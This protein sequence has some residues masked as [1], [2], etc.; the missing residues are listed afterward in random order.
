M[1]SKLL[2]IITVNYNSG[3]LLL[4]TLPKLAHFSSSSGVELI[5]VDGGSSDQS[6]P[7]IEKYK[8]IFTHCIIEKDKGIYDAMNKGIRHSSGE[9]VWFINAGDQPL[10]SPDAL[11]TILSIVGESPVNF[12]YSDLIIGGTIIRQHLDFVTI[13][14]GMINH[15]TIIYKHSLLRQPYDASLKYCSDYGHLINN[16]KNINPYKICEPICLYDF[17]GISSQA[18]RERKLAIWFER[19][20]AQWDSR[21]PVGHKYILMSISIFTIVIKFLFP[22][23]MSFKP[24]D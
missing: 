16:Y 4:C 10:I 24:R 11:I 13:A 21:L 17:T 2:T 9:W 19:L 5:M 18:T 7:L 3:T 8:S 23:I 20:R 14:I 15:Q 6:I 22:K 12:L 1:Y